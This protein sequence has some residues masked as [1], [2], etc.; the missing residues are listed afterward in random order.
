MAWIAPQTWVAE[1][2]VTA[3][4]MNESLRDNML[5]TEAAKATTAGG[6]F[7]QSTYS[8]RVTLSFPVSAR[9]DIPNVLFGSD[10]DEEYTVRPPYVT[11]PRAASYLVWY[12]ARQ[13][14]TAGSPGAVYFMP[15]VVGVG[16][17]GT[18]KMISYDNDAVRQSGWCRFDLSTISEVPE[19]EYT[20]GLAYGTLGTNAAG[21]WAQRAITVLP[22][23]AF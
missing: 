5:E 15:H 1:T 9:A 17:I 13:E 11:V 21:H 20:F 12:S 6:I 23:G 16:S 4:Q 14:V 10:A 8:D 3:A 7:T 2:V 22:I 18:H 19:E